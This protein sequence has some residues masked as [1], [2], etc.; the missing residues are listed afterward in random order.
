MSVGY[1]TQNGR[2]R[3]FYESINKDSDGDH[4]DE[5]RHGQLRFEGR[6]CLEKMLERELG[7]V[8][9]I[10]FNGLGKMILRVFLRVKVLAFR[11]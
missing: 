9:P 6:R 10:S 2:N 1:L 5:H 8:A 3:A 7:R 11:G 4:Q